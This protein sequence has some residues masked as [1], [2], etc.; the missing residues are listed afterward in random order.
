MIIELMNIDLL[1]N[2]GVWKENLA[3]MKRIIETV[4]KQRSPEMSKLWL[5]HLNY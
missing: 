4:T 3:K 2:K 5:T 1:R